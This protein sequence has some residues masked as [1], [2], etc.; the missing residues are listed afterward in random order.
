MT[1]NELNTLVAGLW[2]KVKNFIKK[3]GIVDRIENEVVADFIDNVMYDDI[4]YSYTRVDNYIAKEL[5][6][7]KD[8]PAPY[9]LKWTPSNA[10]QTLE[11]FYPYGKITKTLESG[12]GEYDVYNLIPGEDVLCKVTSGGQVLLSERARL[13]GQLRMIKADSLKNIRDIGGWPTLDGK[14]V[15]YGKIIRGCTFSGSNQW[16]GTISITEEDKEVMLKAIGVTAELD[17]DQEDDTASVLG[18]TVEYIL[19]EPVFWD[20]YTDNIISAKTKIAQIIRKVIDLLERGKVVYIHCFGG[21]DRTGSVIMLLLAALGVNESDMLKDYE[22]TGFC[23]D[24]TIGNG[25][26]RNSNTTN[27]PLYKCLPVVKSYTGETLSEKW[28][29]LMYEAGITQVEIDTLRNLLLEDTSEHELTQAE[30]D[31]ICI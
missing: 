25:R 14:R 11:I 2:A 23:P 27:R 13:G 26:R 28:I 8:Q 6:S 4:D 29:N 18:N 30:I 12:V 31:A 3:Q 7:R 10:T 22:L 1:L 15:K 19:Q 21:A 24:T 9:K 20:V 17:L 5:S 16:S